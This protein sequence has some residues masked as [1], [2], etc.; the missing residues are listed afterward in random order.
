[1]VSGAAYAPRVPISNLTYADG[2]GWRK[3]KGC[4]EGT[5]EEVLD[6]VFE[7]MTRGRTY[8]NLRLGELG[9]GRQDR[10][11]ALFGQVIL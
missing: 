2:A 4:I 7:K 3:E 6:D 10:H 1:M 5:R 11:R 8:P 9:R